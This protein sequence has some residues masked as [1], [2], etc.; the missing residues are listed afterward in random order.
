MSPEVSVN[1]HFE[2]EPEAEGVPSG[3]ECIDSAFACSVLHG[4]R[5]LAGKPAATASYFEHGVVPS[6][7]ERDDN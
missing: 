2:D 7:F 6:A 3:E 5:S 1:Q 4:K